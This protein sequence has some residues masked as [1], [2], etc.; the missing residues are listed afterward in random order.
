MLVVKNVGLN[1]NVVL[2]SSELASSVLSQII[3]ES[4]TDDEDVCALS[5]WAHVWIHSLDT[6]WEHREVTGSPG[7]GVESNSHEKTLAFFDQWKFVVDCAPNCVG[8]KELGLGQSIT[9]S[10]SE[11]G[12]LEV[13][14]ESSTDDID[15][16]VTIIWSNEW[17][18]IIDNTLSEVMEVSES[19]FDS[20]KLDSERNRS[21]VVLTLSMVLLVINWSF[22]K[23][24]HS[25]VLVFVKMHWALD[26]I[27]MDS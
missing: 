21:E 10:A 4:F 8:I 22:S 14:S 16:T 24:E 23:F 12:V 11:L 25:S 1:N 18:D 7:V 17:S 5:D 27:E 15:S 6:V 19:L 2:F 13:I 3:V 9:D 20:L 26:K